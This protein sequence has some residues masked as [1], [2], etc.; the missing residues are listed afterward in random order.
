MQMNFSVKI[1]IVLTLMVIA[2]FAIAPTL[3]M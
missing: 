3:N 2:C 1:M